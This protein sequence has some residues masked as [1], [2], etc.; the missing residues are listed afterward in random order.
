MDEGR[1]IVFTGPGVL[2]WE[3]FSV[4]D[5]DLGPTELIVRTRVTVISP[6]TELARYGGKTLRFGG[7]ATTTPFLPGYANIG[8]ILAAGS[9]VPA[10]P[11]DRVYTMATHTSIARVDMRQDLCVPVPAGLADEDAVFARLAT[12]S[13][14][15]L[16]NTI[17]RGGDSIAVIGLG[18]VGN[19]AAQI[20]QIC[21]MSVSAIDRSS[22]R[23]EIAERCGLRHIHG[24]A[25]AAELA[26]RHRLVVEASGSAEA[27]AS[28]VGL[29]ASGG[30][31]V[32]IGAPWGGAENSVPSG[33][34]TGEIFLRFLRLRSGSEWEIPRQP[35]PLAIGSIHQNS[36]TALDWLATGRLQAQPL[37]THRLPAEAAEEAYD[38]LRSRPDEYLGVI[39]Q[40]GAGR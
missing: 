4:D 31:I 27:L 16:L 25:D 5:H 34:L 23:R 18:L 36:V 8:T 19:L 9:A 28:A 11:G 37:I 3:T 30:E 10:A 32:M 17:A 24:S 1:R 2:E 14:T 20:F 6:G 38:G 21:G 35:E 7:R 12:V 26:Q 40:W 15:T 33:R 39:L 29:A 13:M 22:A